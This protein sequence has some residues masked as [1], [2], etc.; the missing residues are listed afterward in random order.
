MSGALCQ[1]PGAGEM[2]FLL[3]ASLPPHA[4]HL[5]SLLF[6]LISYN[7]SVLDQNIIKPHVCLAFITLY[8]H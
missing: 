3:D 1:E 8:N 2:C 6:L 4:P 7:F 5:K